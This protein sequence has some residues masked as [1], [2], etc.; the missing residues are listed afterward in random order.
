MTAATRGVCLIINNYDFT[1]SIKTLS[2]R[3][4]TQFDLGKL[5]F[6]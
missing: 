2:K 1:N 5:L 3:E 6:Y 4:G